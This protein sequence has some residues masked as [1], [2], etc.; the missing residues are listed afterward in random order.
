MI[1]KKSRIQLLL[2][3]FLILSI[4]AAA[5]A[6]GCGVVKRD[7]K[8]G[9]EARD[10]LCRDKMTPPSSNICVAEVLVE[11][12]GK[13]GV[14]YPGDTHKTLVC[15]NVDCSECK[16][17]SCEDLLKKNCRSVGGAGGR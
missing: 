17:M 10:C 4:P 7:P 14:T 2:F 15:D 12:D 6:Q 8:T 13:P 3:S 11:S 16:S 1:L 9:A 5:N